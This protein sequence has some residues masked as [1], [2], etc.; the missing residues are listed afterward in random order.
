MRTSDNEYHKAQRQARKASGKVELR[1]WTTWKAVFALSFLMGRSGKS[2]HE[3][4]EDAI[5]SAYRLETGD[6]V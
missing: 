4:V 5:L 1:A 6:D 3:V 2:K